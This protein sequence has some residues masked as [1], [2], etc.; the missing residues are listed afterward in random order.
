MGTQ[1]EVE[2]V[3][4]CNSP[5]FCSWYNDV[6]TESIYTNLNMAEE[7]PFATVIETINSCVAI[8]EKKG[9]K[10]ICVDVEEDYTLSVCGSRP[11]NAEEIAY[12]EKNTKR[13]REHERGRE[14]AELK[15]L[16]EKYANENP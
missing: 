9:C 4:H 7:V 16:Q 15:R 11:L 6:A 1:K 3:E 8:L 10:N 14:L 2:L 12:K 13:Q 5:E